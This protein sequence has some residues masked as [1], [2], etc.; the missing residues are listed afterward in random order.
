MDFKIQFIASESYYNEAHSEAL[1]TNV[2]NKFEPF[3]MMLLMAIGCVLYLIDQNNFLGLFPKLIF[4][5]G[6]INLFAIY[7]KK[8][9][10]M[11]QVKNSKTFGQTMELQFTKDFIDHKGPSTDGKIK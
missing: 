11:K 6:L 1:S 3:L 2:L 10:W 7:F 4:G 5:Y 8:K 9:F